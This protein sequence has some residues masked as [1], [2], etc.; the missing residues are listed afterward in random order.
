MKKLMNL[1]DKFREPSS[2]A[3]VAILLSAFGVSISGEQWTAIVN[4]G[5]AVAGAGAIFLPEK[6]AD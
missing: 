5:I 4:L 3:G 6:G 1:L 2:W